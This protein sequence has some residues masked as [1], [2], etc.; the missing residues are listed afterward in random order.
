MPSAS[1]LHGGR[2]TL[3]GVRA[4]L[5]TANITGIEKDPIITLYGYSG[6][7]FA[8]EY[9]SSCQVR[10]LESNVSGRPP[11]CSRRTRLS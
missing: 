10:G 2:T 3:D 4:V 7:A 9:V 11:R 1:G 8:G 6:G 5:N